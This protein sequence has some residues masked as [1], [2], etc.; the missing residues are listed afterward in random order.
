MKLIAQDENKIVSLNV[1]ELVIRDI[2]S[3]LVGYT[4]ISPDMD[5]ETKQGIRSIRM[6]LKSTLLV[7][8][9]CIRKQLSIETK[10]GKKDD[11]VD[12]YINQVVEFIAEKLKDQEFNFKVGSIDENATIAQIHPESLSQED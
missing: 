6:L 9:D 8:G 10:P 4:A 5:D 3:G 7:A 1:P 11:L 12:W 2:L